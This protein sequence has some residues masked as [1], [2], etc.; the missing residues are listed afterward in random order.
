MTEQVTEGKSSLDETTGTWKVPGP[1]SEQRDETP[2]LVSVFSR[3]SVVKGIRLTSVADSLGVV[4]SEPAAVSL[5]VSSKGFGE[6]EFTE[7][8]MEE[9]G[10][11][12]SFQMFLVGWI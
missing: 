2:K 9:T 3:R 11:A 10:Q 8:E 12:V 4:P 7:V 1:I 6:E 5:V